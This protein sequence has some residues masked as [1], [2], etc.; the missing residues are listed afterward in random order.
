[1]FN[2]ERIATVC[3]MTT[4][5]LNPFGYDA[6]F[7]YILDLTG[8]YWTTVRILYCLAGLFFGLYLYFSKVNLWRAAKKLV[9]EHVNI[10][11]N[12]KSK[13]KDYAK[14]VKNTKRL[15]RT[16]DN[17]HRRGEGGAG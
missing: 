7:K 14:E 1:M 13:I 9:R 4:M 12:I 5:F 17:K 3:L 10:V 2:R 16:G 6:L 15:R 8:D 11:K